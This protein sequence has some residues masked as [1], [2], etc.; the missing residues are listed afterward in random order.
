MKPTIFFIFNP[1]VIKID[2][3]G[4]Y[5]ICFNIS[6]VYDANARGELTEDCVQIS[7]WRNNMEV[8]LNQGHSIAS[9]WLIYFLKIH[10]AD[11]QSEPF[12]CS[13]LDFT[14]TQ[15]NTFTIMTEGL[16]F[17]DNT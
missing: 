9:R 16:A 2:F 11:Q 6:Y 14:Q 4:K 12:Q 13:S 3:F 7:S 17:T 15:H 8:S 1:V 5:S 10:K